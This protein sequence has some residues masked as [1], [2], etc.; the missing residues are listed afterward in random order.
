MQVIIG[1]AAYNSMEIPISIRLTPDEL[2]RV[3]EMAEQGHDI[4]HATRVGEWSDDMKT[5]HMEI[6]VSQNRAP[7]VN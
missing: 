2:K 3:V 7:G 6:F 5:Q 4:L 1:A